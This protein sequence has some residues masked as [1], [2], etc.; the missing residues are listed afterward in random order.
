M[1]I[2]YC[3]LS[4]E[5]IFVFL[6]FIY[7]ESEIF[8]SLK[9]VSSSPHH[10]IVKVVSLLVYKGIS[11]FFYRKNCSG[12]KLKEM[13]GS[14]IFTDKAKIG[15]ESDATDPKTGLRYYQVTYLS[16]PMFQKI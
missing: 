14:G 6:F 9:I 16:C 1:S 2:Y 13:T 11:C 10:Y 4:N 7:L 15:S 12:Y 3:S 5:K 8:V